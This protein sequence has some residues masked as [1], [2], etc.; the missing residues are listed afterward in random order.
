MLG[1]ILTGFF[2][3][4]IDTDD[5]R[6]FTC[7]LSVYR[8]RLSNQEDDGSRE[9]GNSTEEES[10]PSVV[11]GGWSCEAN[12]DCSFLTSGEERG[13]YVPNQGKKKKK[14]VA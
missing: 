2:P 12:S 5:F 3:E 6:A 10:G 11:V 7:G 1:R 14:G 13:W 8:R 9:K 4:T